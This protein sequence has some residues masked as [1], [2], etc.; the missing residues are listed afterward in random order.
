MPKSYE[1]L[2]AN[3]EQAERSAAELLEMAKRYRD[4]AASLPVGGAPDAGEGGQ[5]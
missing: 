2:I 1:T 4:E 5:C 3:A